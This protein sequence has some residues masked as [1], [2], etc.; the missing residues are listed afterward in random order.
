MEAA[1]DNTGVLFVNKGLAENP[2]RPHWR[3]QATIDGV[4]YWMSSWDKKKNGQP[5]QQLVFNLKPGAANKAGEMTSGYSQQSHDHP[6]AEPSPPPAPPPE[7]P[8][9]GENKVNIPF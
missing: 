3:G 9:T 8:A 2:K 7:S 1:R 4:E 5:F 6:P